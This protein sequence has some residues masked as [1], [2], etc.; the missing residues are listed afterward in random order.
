MDD[1]KDYIIQ[2]A[3]LAITMFHDAI[4]AFLNQDEANIR[5]IIGV[6]EAVDALRNQINATLVRLLQDR[7]ISFDVFDS[8]MV[9]TRRLERVSDQ[10]RNICMEALYMCTGE[11]AKHSGSSTFRIL[12]LDGH[13]S[14][15][16]PMAEAMAASLGH[17]K[18]IFSS[19]GIE[20]RPVSPQTIEFMKSKGLDL[21]RFQPRSIHQIPNLD[22]YQ[23]V[24]TLSKDA[25]K[26]FSQCSNKAVVLEW[27]VPDPS[28]NKGSADEVQKAYNETFQY[29][30][31][32]IKALVNAVIEGKI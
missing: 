28:E 5:S 10:A 7:T 6:E 4:E 26:V 2:M 22:H 14:C 3:D 32:H 11:Y 24:I 1:L 20:P 9:I 8:L 31:D 27:L 15:R 12:F 16:S 18:F 17:P 30:Q 19:A 29:L 21:F 23:I 25:L 13:H